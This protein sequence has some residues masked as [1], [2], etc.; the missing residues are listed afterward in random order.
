M[1]N[2]R[3]HEGLFSIQTAHSLYQFRADE[4]GVLQ[5]LY[6]GEP[7]GEDMRYLALQMDRGFSGNPY[8][9]QGERGYSLDS[10][11]QEY[12]CGGAGDYRAPA[13][14]I[15]CADGACSADLRYESH[16][17][18]AGRE[19]IPGLPAARSAE[20]TE[21]L[22]ITLRD[23]ASGLKVLLR[24]SVWPGE[25]VLARSAVLINEGGV[26]IVIE[27]A[28]SASVDFF[29]GRYEVLHFHG[30]HCM[31]RMAERLA[32]PVGVTAFGSERGM[33]SHQHN[34][35]VILCDP[36]ATER[37]GEC[38]GA[39]LVY[40]GNHLEEMEVNQAG[41]TRLVTGIHPAGFHWT[42]QPGE[43]FET[44][45]A[46]L[47]YSPRGLNALSACYHR[48][49]R[50]H[51]VPQ[52][53]RAARRPVL[54]NSWEAAYFDFN[55][56][57]I[58]RFA[59]SARDLGIDMLVLD[60]GWFGHRDDDTTSLGDWT[61]NEGKLGCSMAELSRRIHSL[62][63][64]FGLWFEP[65]MI[66]EDSD[67]YRAHP[68]WAIAEPGR[69][70]TVSRQQLV[71][72]MSRPEVVDHIFNA[73]CGVL[74][75]AQIEYVKWDFNRSVCNWYSHALPPERQGELPHR[76]MLG[77]YSLLER[78]RARYPKLVIEGCSGGGGRFDA[79]MLYYCPQIWC[80]DDS[81]AVER[82]TIQRG[83]SYGYPP[84]TMGAH[85][86]ASPNH[87]T[88]RSAPLDIRGIV[89]QA[90]TFGY[91]LD[92]GR[93]TEKE[94]E[95]VAAQ[96][97]TMRE[98]EPLITEGTYY[99]L[100]AGD[101]AEDFA[102]WM[103]VSPDRR[104]ALLSVAA[105]RVRANGPFLHIALQG[106]DPETRY[107]VQGTERCLTGAALMRGGFN[108]PPLRGDY[109]ALQLHLTAAAD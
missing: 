75:H 93:L 45:E 33:S 74:D 55:A 36:A 60:D 76:F 69:R 62:G 80:S 19:P 78:L 8:E 89:A 3:I 73:M 95:A 4:H 102:A 24:Y 12:P 79:G 72:D 40:S 16:R 57:R 63:M 107:R 20:D 49:I 29:T 77:T 5:H 41:S 28:A 48:M 7:T 35:F 109:P 46:L 83:T 30:R 59:E 101:P 87:Q 108:L 65:E 104:E 6:W 25:E 11:P 64:T 103:T 92:P 67:L 99:R 50:R 100:D 98:V 38:W 106:L 10:L 13:L 21:T 39:M 97:Q 56:E 51:V 43:R 82:L 32:L 84:E 1:K 42:L 61:V 70:P 31:E 34:P 23:A 94:R 47:A 14:R 52:E 90:G 58:V 17:A 53:L 26:P 71:L 86:S 2:I 81:D 27:K 54:V 68:D 22:E 85:V 66:S 9:Q 37:Q 44:P 91:E 96:V 18:F 15:R 105:T 88:G